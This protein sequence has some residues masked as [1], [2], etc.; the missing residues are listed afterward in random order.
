MARTE[1]RSPVDIK[2]NSIVHHRN[3]LRREPEFI[4][5]ERLP[6]NS[7]PQ[8]RKDREY[9]VTYRHIRT[10]PP[11][12]TSKEAIKRLNIV[13]HDAIAFFTELQEG[14]EAD[15]ALLSYVGPE[16]LN[17]IWQDKLRFDQPPYQPHQHDDGF[18]RLLE[19]DAARTASDDVYGM[20][21]QL[22]VYLNAAVDAATFEMKYS[23]GDNRS[24]AEKL[25]RMAQ[26][27][28]AS[29][30]RV[31][32]QRAEMDVLMTDLEMLVVL[33]KRHGGL[34]DDSETEKSGSRNGNGSSANGNGNGTRGGRMRMHPRR[35]SSYERPSVVD[36]D[37][38]GGS[39]GIV[40][41]AT[42]SGFQDGA[43]DASGEKVEKT[44]TGEWDNG[45][46][47]HP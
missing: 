42:D 4:Y 31:F 39:E 41:M 14:F 20:L 12:L 27:I 30:E 13:L 22:T 15:T 33:L 37:D 7:P 40:D 2:G 28:D 34:H 25:T 21:K 26:D 9:E 19:A 16:V 6:P 24:L 5:E 8:A 11:L 1:M 17:Y 47:Q 43:S 35:A 3:S 32:K 38:E 18:G 29:R 36:D 23:A 46:C 10:Q 44:E 45:T